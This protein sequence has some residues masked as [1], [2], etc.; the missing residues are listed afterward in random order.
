MPVNEFRNGVPL[1]LASASPRRREL[2]TSA[3]VAVEVV[4][5]EIDESELPGEPPSELVLRLASEKCRRVAARYPDRWVLAADT[6]VAIDGVSLGKPRDSEEVMQMLTRLSG[7]VHQVITGMMLKNGARSIEERERSTTEV[8][9]AVLTPSEIDWYARTGEP[10]DKAGGYG[11]Q[12][13]AAQ[14]VR[15]VRGS[16]SNVVG[17]DLAW[18]VDRLRFHRFVS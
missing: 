10:F 18:I 6:T 8:T 9:M 4:P 1:V 13:Q 14:F 11:I 7:R 16:Y 2:L 12:G 15:E 3:G 5:A 17:L